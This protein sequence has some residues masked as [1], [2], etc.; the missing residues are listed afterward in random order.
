MECKLYFDGKTI[1]LPLIID[2][3]CFDIAIKGLPV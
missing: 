1:T 3:E 2:E